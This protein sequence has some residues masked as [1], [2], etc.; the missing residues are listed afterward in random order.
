MSEKK[1]YIPLRVDVI[2]LELEGGI[3]TGSSTLYSGGPT[4]DVPQVDNWTFD[5]S[6]GSS[7]KGFADEW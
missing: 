5:A 6:D 2:Y 1:E 4:D 7:N 3:A